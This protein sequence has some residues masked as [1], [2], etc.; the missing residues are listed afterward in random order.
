MLVRHCLI[1]ACAVAGPLLQSVHAQRVLFVDSAADSSGDGSTW[2]RAIPSLRTAISSAAPGDQI[3]VAAGTYRAG[4]NRTDAFQL[5]EGVEIYGGFVGNE[6]PGAF[7]LDERD[8]EQD[9]TILEGEIGSIGYA[10][11][12]FHVV[13]AADVTRAAVLDGVVIARANASGLTQSRQDVGGG[14]LVVGA[15][16]TVSR[17][18]FLNHRSGSRG[19]AVHIASGSPLFSHCRFIGNQT[20][21]TQAANNL[22]GAI[23]YSGTSASPAEPLFVN[24]LFTGNRA[25]VG[26]GGSGGALYAGEFGLAGIIQCTFLNNRADTLT[27]GVHG[28]SDIVNSIFFGNQD[29]NGFELTAQLRG[30]ATAR[31]S[32]IQ[33]GWPGQNNLNA[34]PLFVEAAGA[35]GISGTLDDDARLAPGSPCIDAGDNLAWPVEIP[36]LDLDGVRRF[37]NDP[38]TPDTGNPPGAAVAD[39]GAYELQFQC[40][41]NAQCD[42][43]RYCNGQESCQS[44]TCSPGQTVVCTDSVSCTHDSCSEMTRNCTHA[45]DDSLCDNAVF[46]DGA[47]TCNPTTGCMSGSAPICDDQISCTV[48]QCDLVADRCS[49]EADSALCD[50]SVFCN[51]AE[52]CTATGCEAGQAPCDALEICDEA[53]R[54]CEPVQSECDVAE[55]CNDQNPCTDDACV[56]GTCERTFNQILCNDGNDCTAA[57][58]CTQ[59]SCVGTVIINCGQPPVDPGPG[60]V[61]NPTDPIDETPPSDEEPPI[62]T[63]E[64]DSP[65]EEPDDHPDETVDEEPPVV[66]CVVDGNCEPPA[67]LDED[68]DGVSDEDDQC[69]FTADEQIVDSDG[70]SLD[71]VQPGRGVLDADSQNRCGTCG[72][73]GGIGVVMMVCVPG[74]VLII[75][76]P[77]GRKLPLD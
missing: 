74:T 9:V 4:S 76:R 54:R 55:D 44:G 40:S 7:H 58:R 45:P 31:R 61:G 62:E 35:D 47:E 2:A 3:W 26:N 70:C 41:T 50:D 63:P 46:C 34:N 71:Q 49:F 28:A 32:L 1:A 67:D 25:G 59:G 42:D 52:A 10:D 51:G 36:P 24:C 13:V 75:G 69:P 23:Y 12:S 19:A 60:D 21:V 16:P 66:D 73:L 64:D 56:S 8:L 57:D 38:F 27:G 15:S 20:T 29:R 30:A 37:V 68:G 53:E 5:S 77:R 48:D 14:M 33:G 17:C 22:G 18:L 6:V 43:G 39:L 72:A 65:I 11:N